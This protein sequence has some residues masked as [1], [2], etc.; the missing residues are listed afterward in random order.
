MK[1]FGYFFKQALTFYLFL[2]FQW[3]GGLMKLDTGF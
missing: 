2:S 1:A 3:N